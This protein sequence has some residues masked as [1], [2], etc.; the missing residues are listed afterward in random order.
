MEKLCSQQNLMRL[1]NIKNKI[2]DASLQK[3]RTD[4]ET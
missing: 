1:E 3:R 2:I 4:I